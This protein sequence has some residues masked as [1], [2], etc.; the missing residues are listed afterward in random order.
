MIKLYKREKD[1]SLRYAEYWIDDIEIIL[2][3][4]KVGR[5]G[6]VEKYFLGKD[7]NSEKSFVS[8]FLKKYEPQNYKRITDEEICY[9]AVQFPMKSLKGNKRDHWLKD[10][11]QEYLNDWLGWVGLGNVEGFD[12]GELINYPK[13]YALTIFCEVVDEERGIKAIKSCL[14]YSRLDY[15][16][17]KIATRPY[18]SDVGFQLKYSAKKNDTFFSL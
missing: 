13:T 2:H 16:V 6:K 18:L 8:F 11:V 1:N 14:R 3:T 12:M 9:I 10:K 4:G 5:K 15:G 17:V 7:F